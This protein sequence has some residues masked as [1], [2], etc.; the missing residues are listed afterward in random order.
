MWRIVSITMLL[1]LCV[2]F[3]TG[4]Y[5]QDSTGAADGERL[6]PTF[7]LDELPEVPDDYYGL[8]VKWT[9]KKDAG[10]GVIVRGA[11]FDPVLYIAHKHFAEGAELASQEERSSLLAEVRQF[12]S[13]YLPFEVFLSHQ[14]RQEL[15]KP[16]HW[17]FTLQTSQG[18]AYQ[19][20][21]TRDVRTQFKRAYTGPYWETSFLVLFPSEDDGGQ[22]FTPQTKWLRLEYDGPCGKGQMTWEFASNNTRGG[23]EQGFEVYV[24][25]CLSAVV[26]IL[27]VFL[28]LTRPREDFSL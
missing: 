10:S 8:L 27:L 16:S 7:N 14:N 18:K 25:V 6:T 19:P 2:G 13:A 3:G 23:W 11:Y 24:K 1:V 22:V 12:Y 28:W 20:L 5:A 9:Q 4:T 21:G 17:H 26:I 15:L